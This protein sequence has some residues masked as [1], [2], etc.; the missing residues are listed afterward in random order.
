MRQAYNTFAE[1]RLRLQGGTIANGWKPIRRRFLACRT[2]PD[3]RPPKTRPAISSRP[4]SRRKRGRTLARHAQ[5]LAGSGYSVLQNPVVAGR[6][7][8]TN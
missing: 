7:N 1:G 4:R 3:R 6:K 2:T 8:P 5:L